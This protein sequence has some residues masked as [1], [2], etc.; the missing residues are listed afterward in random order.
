M[1][2]GHDAPSS[3]KLLDLLHRMA[4]AQPDRP[5]DFL[6]RHPGEDEMSLRES[7]ILFADHIAEV[8]DIRRTRGGCWGGQGKEWMVCI[9]D[10]LRALRTQ[11]DQ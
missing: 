1:S 2:L 8:R 5:L 10:N 4:K 9:L 11:T 7:W 3:P 6:P